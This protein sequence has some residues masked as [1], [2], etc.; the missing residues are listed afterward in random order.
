VQLTVTTR[1]TTD[2]VSVADALGL[3]YQNDKGI[4]QFIG[5]SAIDKTTRTVTM[6]TNHFSDWTLV[7]W[8]T[9]SPISSQLLAKEGR[10]VDCATVHC[11][12]PLALAD[13]LLVP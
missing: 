13:E 10:H 4:W 9:L 1:P 8:M 7:Q 12:A 11:P 5:A 6:S 3:A 2:S